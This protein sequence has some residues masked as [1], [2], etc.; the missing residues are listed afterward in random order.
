MS[1]LADVVSAVFGDPVETARLKRRADLR[2]RIQIARLAERRVESVQVEIDKLE[3][4]KEEAASQCER[5]CEPMRREVQRID[6]KQAELARTG[7]PL[8]N[9]AE[10]RRAGLL[11][12]I[13]G[14]TAEL[15][16]AI[17][18]IDRQL[19]PL[20]KERTAEKMKT[21]PLTTGPHE[22]IRT[23]SPAV[24][25][26]MDAT[27]LVTAA[28]RRLQ[29]SIAERRNLVGRPTAD[30]DLLDAELQKLLDDVAERQAAATQE[31]INES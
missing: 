29:T 22:L 7:E 23:A 5:I 15:D 13:R 24:R 21:I 3:A 28:I 14:A 31:A 12:Q 27:E 2:E 11:S 1:M 30:G 10:V 26:R 6:G 19:A 16:E 25:A 18:G 8:D 20:I 4:S 17:K 9:D